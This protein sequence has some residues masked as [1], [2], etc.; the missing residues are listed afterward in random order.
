MLTIV[1]VIVNLKYGYPD[2][3]ENKTIFRLRQ[4]YN[5]LLNFRIIGRRLTLGLLALNA[6]DKY[7]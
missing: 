6:L 2:S 1:F 3:L 7:S 4:R 5:L